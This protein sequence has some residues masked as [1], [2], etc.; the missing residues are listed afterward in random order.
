MYFTTVKIKNKERQELE[1]MSINMPLHAS[2]GWQAEVT[3]LSWVREL[4]LHQEVIRL[5]VPPE[6]DD[7][8]EPFR[9]ATTVFPKPCNPRVTLGTCSFDSLGSTRK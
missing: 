4:V 6:P 9:A 1:G 7:R 5:G 3:L 8:D 2:W